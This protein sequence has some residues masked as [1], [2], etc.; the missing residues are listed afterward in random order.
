MQMC[1][2]QVLWEFQNRKRRSRKMKRWKKKQ[3]KNRISNFVN[4]N[5][6]YLNCISLLLFALVW[7]GLEILSPANKWRQ[8]LMLTAIKPATSQSILSLFPCH[9]LLC[10][11]NLNEQT[12]NI[13][14]VDVYFSNGHER[15]MLWRHTH[16]HTHTSTNGKMLEK[17]T[18]RAEI[19]LIS[20]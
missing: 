20:K 11:T 17:Y 15:Y 14:F 18:Q 16:T 8:Y 2:V 9:V 12:L 19:H 1:V 10:S 7:F 13:H 4:K 3:K 6:A 5:D